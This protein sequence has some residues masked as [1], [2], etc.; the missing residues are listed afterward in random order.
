[1][2]AAGGT[3]YF[4]LNAAA[5]ALRPFT[6]V[7][8]YFSFL[9]RSDQVIASEDFGAGFGLAVV[10]DE[11][12]AV[13]VTAVPTPISQSGSDLWFAHKHLLGSIFK[14]SDNTQVASRSGYVSEMDSKAMR[15]VDVG[16]DIVVVGESMTATLGG[17]CILGVAGR[18]LVKVN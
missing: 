2:A 11:A 16:Q 7:R 6:I 8:T 18:M 10:S 17:G 12:T 4:S 3:I 13:G 1:M 15:K 14:D 9:L 5:L